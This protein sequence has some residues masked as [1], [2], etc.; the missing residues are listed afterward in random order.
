[1]K[2]VKIDIAALKAAFA[3]ETWR[4]GAGSLNMLWNGQ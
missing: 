4:T 3:G 1:M 2:M